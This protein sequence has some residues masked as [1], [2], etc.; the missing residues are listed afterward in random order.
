M[1]VLALDYGSARTGVAVSDPTGTLARPLG[2]VAAASASPT[3]SSGCI[4]VIR[5][6]AAGGDRRRPA[7]DAARRA[8]R[9][10]PTRRPSS[11][12]RCAARS[13]SR[14]RPTTS[15]SPRCSPAA[16]TRARPRTCSRATSNGR[17]QPL[18]VAARDHPPAADR[19]RH[20]RG[21][22]RRRRRR[23]RR[24]GRHARDRGAAPP[25]TTAAAA[26]AEAVP[27]R[28]PRGLHARAR[29]PTASTAVAEIAE[30]KRHANVR[31]NRTAYLAASARGV[32]PCFG[33]KPQHE[34]RGLPLPGDLRLPARTRPRGSSS[35]DQLEAFCRNWRKVD[36]ALRALEEPDAV[37]RADD[38][39]DDREGG[40]G[41]RAS[42]S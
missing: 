19:R 34:P 14:S 24:L 8:R 17:Q 15:G 11:S 4:E 21:A 35:R 7:A 26:A 12:R 31:L 9:C 28:L 39:V 27:H 3:A 16:T 36:L 32:V 42:A 18:T 29:W 37:R 2:V 22:R 40:A 13:R 38:R 33:R 41:A 30:R 10:R 25:T 1:K 20:A 23:R 6:E 5:I